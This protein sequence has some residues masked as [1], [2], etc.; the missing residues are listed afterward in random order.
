MNVEIWKEQEI[1]EEEE[2]GCEF[3]REIWQLLYYS[4]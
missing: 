4:H 2:D 3:S 1:R